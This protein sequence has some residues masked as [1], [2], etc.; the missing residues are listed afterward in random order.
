MRRKLLILLG[1]GLVIGVILCIIAVVIGSLKS[2]DATMAKYEVLG[3]A[4]TP[5]SSVLGDAAYHAKERTAQ[6]ALWGV[7]D[8]GQVLVNWMLLSLVVVG[9]IMLLRR[10]RT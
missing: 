9:S 2:G 8:Y 7:I 10:G 1:P 5:L 6:G 3:V 4:S